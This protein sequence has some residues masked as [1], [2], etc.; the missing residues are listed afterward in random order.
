M[1]ALRYLHVIFPLKVRSHLAESEVP[2]AN[3]INSTGSLMMQYR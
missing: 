2:Y 3:E 1:L